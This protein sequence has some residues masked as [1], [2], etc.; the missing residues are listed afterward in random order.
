MKK[1]F[2][3]ILSYLLI[4]FNIYVCADE[5]KSENILKIGADIKYELK[6]SF[7]FSICRI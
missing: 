7:R 2:K 1:V 5:N 6:Q 3:I 4:T